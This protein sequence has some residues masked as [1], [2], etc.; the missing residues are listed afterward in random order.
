MI[1][2]LLFLDG[3]R[4]IAACA[5]LFQHMFEDTVLNAG[6][7]ILSPGLF[8]VV[9]FFMISG[10]IIP[11]SVG[12]TLNPDKFVINRIFRIFPAYLTVLFITLLLGWS[13]VGGWAQLV[14]G[15]EK[16][17]VWLAANMLTVAEY[18]GKP[19]VIGVAWTLP[20]EFLWYALFALLFAIY[21]QS[22][23]LRLTIGFS[24]LL[25][26]LTALAVHFGIRLP[27]GRLSLVNAASVGYLFY[28]HHMGLLSTRGLALG[29]LIFAT[30][31]PFSFIVT[32]TEFPHPNVMLGN[33]LISWAAAFL[34]FVAVMTSPALRNSRLLTNGFIRGLGEISYSVYLVHGLTLG[35]LSL[36]G[37]PFAAAILL[38]PALTYG[39]SWLM[40]RHVERPG[41]AMG[42]RLFHNMQNRDVEVLGYF[43]RKL[44]LAGVNREA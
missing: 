37:V 5:V 17:A 38:G 16:D 10:F 21:G 40:Y 13:G 33:I 30:A 19:A 43:F 1:Q 3:L 35:L 31:T 25:L 8:G 14:S 20:M 26:V 34:F 29:G 4:A 9:L 22:F 2:R 42:K 36:A 12:A 23:A 6:F 32:Y 44:G 18:V 15:P 11:Y 39:L 28:L 41:M 27:I 24:L 7:E